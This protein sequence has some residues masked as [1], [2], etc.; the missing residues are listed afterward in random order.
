MSFRMVT[1]ETP[2]IRTIEL[3][4]LPSTSA[5]TIAIAIAKAIHELHGSSC[6]SDQIAAQLKQSPNSSSFRVQIA[7]A[8]TFGLVTSGQG[9]VNLTAL[10]TR[11]CDPQQ[12]KSARVEAFLSVPLYNAVY[13]KFKG[14]ALPPS[15]GL[16][17]ALVSIG[18]AQKQK[19]RARQILQR[20]AQQA[21]FF[22]FGNDRLVMPAIK[23]G[24]GVLVPPPIDEPEG[25]KKK[26]TKD[27]DEE[28]LHPFIKG[29]LKK[30]PEP[31]TE[32]RSE[33]RA[34]WLQAA[35]NIFD[36]MYTDSDDSRRALTIGFQKNSAN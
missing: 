28:E 36:L 11:I 23:Q 16:E 27:E 22:Q 15:A 29:L 8:K 20:S 14:S 35:I 7:S 32:W 18:V 2:V 13:E 17:A 6:Q 1:F 30:L 12:E 4:E 19:E 34:K 21:G 25:E 10:G 33:D 26:K 5:L 24:T 3:M 31:E 9:A